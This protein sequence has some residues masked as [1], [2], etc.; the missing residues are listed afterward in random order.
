MRS[1]YIRTGKQR[2]GSVL[3]FILVKLQRHKR[4][5]SVSLGPHAPPLAQSQTNSRSCAEAF[6]LQ[7]ST[8]CPGKTK[9]S[10]AQTCVFIAAIVFYCAFYLPRPDTTKLT[11]RDRKWPPRHTQS[12]QLWI[13]NNAGTSGVSAQLR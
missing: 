13:S 11:K 2:L 7:F 6:M 3:C 5:Q 4:L 9:A 12:Q 1:E 10:P 8:G